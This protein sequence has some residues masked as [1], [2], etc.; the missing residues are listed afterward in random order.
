MK[1]I[2]LNKKTYQLTDGEKVSGTLTDFK[3]E[4][5]D[6]VIDVPEGT[7]NIS[8][9]N[10]FSSQVP[11]IKEGRKI[12]YIK[13]HLNGG[14]SFHFEKDGVFTLKVKGLLGNEFF[15][16]NHKKEKL[17][18]MKP[19]LSWKKM[20]YDHEI[21]ILKESGNLLI[22]CGVYAFNYYFGVMIIYAVIL[23][24]LIVMPNLI[25]FIT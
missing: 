14:V 5:Y 22:L 25:F 11:I 24:L 6:A 18:Q 12:G 21:V 17:L 7:Y 8:P 20:R 2:S 13:L 10:F 19:M 4:S 16:E 23:V 9:D 3:W 1:A 15:I